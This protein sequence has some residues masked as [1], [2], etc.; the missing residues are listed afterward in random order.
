MHGTRPRIRLFAAVLALMLL[1]AGE[2][3]A[4]GEWE[5]TQGQGWVMGAGVS[6]PT[7]AEQLAHAYELEQRGEFMDSARQYFL[8]IRNFSNSQEAGVGLQRLARCLFEMENYYTSYKAIE[9]VIETYPNAGRMSDLVA[10]ELSI[11]KKMMVSQT[12]DL[13]SDGRSDPRPANIRRAL[14][15]VNSV[16][17]HDPFGPV[18]PEA[19]LVRGEGNLFLGEIA[20]ARAAF[21]AVLNDFSRADEVIV[22]RARLGSIRCDSLMGEARPA[23]LAEQ[24]EVVREAERKRTASAG[25][26]GAG[27][28]D[29]FDD[30][31]ESIRQTAEV[32]AAKMMEQAAQ[33]RRMGMRNSV[34]AAEFLYKEVVRRYPE[35]SQAREARG[36]LGDIVVPPEEG[37][38]S[39]RWRQLKLN[40]FSWNRDP[41]P[42]W[43]VPQLNPEDMVMVDS[44]LGPIAGVPES[45]LP[46]RTSSSA[47]VRPSAMGNGEYAADYSAPS[48][49][50]SPDSPMPAPVFF[51]AADSG[52]GT[53]YGPPGRPSPVPDAPYSPRIASA[54]PLP[55]VYES[56]LVPLAAAPIPPSVDYGQAPYAGGAGRV[57]PLPFAPVQASLP[58]SA[59]YSAPAPQPTL[60]SLE[61]NTPLSDLVGPAR[62]NS[63]PPPAP[64]PEY[65]AGGY[66]ADPYVSGIRGGEAAYARGGQAAP[67]YP[68]P[69]YDAPGY[70]QPYAGPAYTYQAPT[71]DITAGAPTPAPHYSPSAAGSTWV[72]GEDFR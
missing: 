43:I 54:N 24:I 60:N 72:L 8:L 16:I 12:P 20:A 67:A 69:V 2:S 30:V 32:E 28:G 50:A 61:Y 21:D 36:F 23:E 6:R 25:A 46:S 4:A 37:G 49:S 18:A 55:T 10:I 33:Y 5:W 51:D 9:Q 11:A 47:A 64:M 38:L 58:D 45:G 71:Y 17:D 15:I 44:G 63:G 22:E 70:G 19:Y 29:A 7:A 34:K 39:R 3:R 26:S 68:A 14:E 62:L 35:T 1:A 27:R 59:P 31:N 13:L 41:E 42:A 57:T 48:V 40:P 66:V 65:V 56:D 53:D 52:A